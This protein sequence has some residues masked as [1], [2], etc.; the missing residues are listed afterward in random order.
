MRNRGCRL[1]ALCAALLFCIGCSPLHSLHNRPKAADPTRYL[2]AFQNHWRYRLLDEDM[3][4][5]YGSI[6][7]VLTEQFAVDETVTTA[8]DGAQHPGATVHLPVSLS[9][10]KQA[11]ALYDAFFYDNP[12]FFYVGSVISLEG[13]KLEE[14]SRYNTLLLTYT[15]DAPARAQARAQLTAATE[16]IL[17]E[18]PETADEYE[19]EL[20]LHDRL[21]ERCRYEDAAAAEQ[22]QYPHAFNAYGALVLGEA[23]CEGYSRGMLLLL[24]NAG[25]EG[26]LVTGQSISSGEEH[27][28]NL[29]RINGQ[30]YHLDVTWDDSDTI[31]RHNYFNQT[32]E[33]I[34]L[35]HRLDDDQPDIPCTATA[36]NYFV[37]SGTYLDTYQRQEIAAAIA[38]RVAAGDERI[39]LAFQQDKYNSAL[40]FLKNGSLAREQIDGYLAAS[41]KTMWPYDLYGEAEESILILC[42]Q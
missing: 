1:L 5:C 37:R 30:T 41:H 20:Y 9:S 27:M 42:K 34:R 11:L 4:Q 26:T 19:I 38:R 28:W 32:D 33:R 13:Y 3:Q 2:A 25:I 15:M 40:L 23:V 39:E 16:Q 7:T 18:A 6:Y 17:A 21:A 14:E 12:E 22:E 31:I 36:D 35:S 24:Q 10:T 29:V 8:E